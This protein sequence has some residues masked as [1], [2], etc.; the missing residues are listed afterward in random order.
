MA[1]RDK[2]RWTPVPGD[3]SNRGYCLLTQIKAILESNPTSSVYAVNCQ[4]L[5]Y[6]SNRTKYRLIVQRHQWI[7]QYDKRLHMCQV[8]LHL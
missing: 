7:L 6:K 2:L 1:G 4:G 5:I 8:H 3:Q